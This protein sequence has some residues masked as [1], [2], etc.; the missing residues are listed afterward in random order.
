[1]TCVG[2]NGRK[3]T[4]Q[5]VG[6]R[7]W[8]TPEGYSLLSG[9]AHAAPCAVRRVASF[10]LHT[11]SNTLEKYITIPRTANTNVLKEA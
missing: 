5:K 1:M 4:A 2:V 10:Y 9:R 8:K 3:T 7:Q 11:C 6:K